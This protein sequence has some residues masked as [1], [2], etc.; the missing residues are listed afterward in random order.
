MDTYKIIPLCL[1][2]IWRPR[3]NMVYG[4]GDDT[5]TAYPLISY[6]IEGNCSERRKMDAL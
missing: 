2:R 1:G 5:V 4:S 3:S 6:Y